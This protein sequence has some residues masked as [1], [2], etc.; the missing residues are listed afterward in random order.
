M[1]PPQLDTGAEGSQRSG[2]AEPSVL[3]NKSKGRTLIKAPQA[4]AAEGMWGM[5]LR[6]FLARKELC[7]RYWGEEHHPEPQRVQPPRVLVTL[8]GCG[9]HCH[10]TSPGEPGLC[11]GSGLWREFSKE[12]HPKSGWDAQHPSPRGS[13]GSVCACKGLCD[14]RT[15]AGGFNSCWSPSELPGNIPEHHPRAAAL[16]KRHR[17]ISQQQKNPQIPAPSLAKREQSLSECL[18]T[19]LRPSDAKPPSEPFCQSDTFRVI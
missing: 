3:D 4:D 6:L 17:H 7:G 1:L 18:L 5:Q 10:G 12:A 16:S 9:G 11:P 2:A 14:P 15:W 19:S 13:Q 8:Q